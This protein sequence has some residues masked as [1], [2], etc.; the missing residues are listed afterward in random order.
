MRSVS[1][2][3]IDLRGIIEARKML[4]IIWK[5]K[6]KK[7]N[8]GNRASAREKKFAISN[9]FRETREGRKSLESTEKREKNKKSM[10]QC[11]LSVEAKK[12]EGRN[13]KGREKS[14]S[15][16]P[17]YRLASGK[18][19]S[20]RLLYFSYSPLAHTFLR[21]TLRNRELE[22]WDALFFWI[23]R[24]ISE[25]LIPKFVKKKWVFFNNFLSFLTL[26]SF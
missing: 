26:W 16:S 11:I 10:L 15:P 21:Q 1:K 12:S 20:L 22:C 17:L 19:S 24:E 7:G 4:E 14:P 8:W 25:L 5:L 6:R 23:T 13:G 9:I 18:F 3:C 2:Y